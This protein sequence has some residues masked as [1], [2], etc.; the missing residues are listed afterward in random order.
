MLAECARG[1]CLTAGFHVLFSWLAQSASLMGTLNEDD[2][3]EGA[4]EDA[5]LARAQRRAN[6]AAAALVA[7]V[8]GADVITAMPSYTIL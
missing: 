2:T 3:D 8:S 6:R 7:H 4:A 1:L 5:R